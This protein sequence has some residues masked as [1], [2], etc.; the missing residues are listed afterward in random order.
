MLLDFSRMGWPLRLGLLCIAVLTAIFLLAPILFIVA[1]SFGS[2]QW[3]VFPPPSWTT[4]WYT[5]LF[6][7][8]AW[9]EATW[10]SLKIALL[11]SVLSTVLGFFTSMALVRGRFRGKALLRAF[12]L[13]PMVMPVVV[14]AVA[15]Y[16][17]FLRIGLTGTLPGFVLGHLVI[18]LPFSIIAISN[19][20]ESFDFA[21]E[22]A[23]RICGASEWTLRWRVTVP[24]IRLG[25]A[26]AALFSFLIS[27]DD[28]VLAIF[29]ATPG[30]ETLPVRIWAALR[31]DLSPVIAAASTLLIAIT[32]LFMLISVLLGAR[33]SKTST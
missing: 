4:R 28:V 22:D 2:S 21:L 12:F 1:L 18:A 3:L 13:T 31:Q 27:W 24:S 11:V 6:A 30:A 16:A 32:L 15:L 29:M 9:L 19:S 20:L 23:A 17:L 5:E 26:A 7:E 8:P 10:N 14:L 25:L 33:P